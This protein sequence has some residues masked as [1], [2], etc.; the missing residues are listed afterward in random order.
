MR[1]FFF[2]RS[3]LRALQRI[4]NSFSAFYLIRL[5]FSC[6]LC[7]STTEQ[8]IGEH[9]LLNVTCLPMPYFQPRCRVLLV[10]TISLSLLCHCLRCFQLRHVRPFSLLNCIVTVYTRCC[11]LNILIMIIILVTLYLRSSADILQPP[12][13]S[14]MLCRVLPSLVCMVSHSSVS[15]VAIV[16]V[17]SLLHHKRTALACTVPLPACHAPLLRARSCRQIAP[18]SA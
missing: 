12:A 17:Y 5:A 4:R 10:S 18:H 2:R 15:L 3:P 16:F 6:L 1:F 13:P 9:I 14:L 8:T 11:L 7:S